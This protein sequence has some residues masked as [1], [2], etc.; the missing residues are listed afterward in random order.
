MDN[1]QKEELLNKCNS[2]T[3]AEDSSGV[4]YRIDSDWIIVNDSVYGYDL[5]I[6]IDESNML[7]SGVF[8]TED[9]K[10][11]YGY[12]FANVGTIHQS[13]D[14]NLYKFSAGFYNHVSMFYEAVVKIIQEVLNQ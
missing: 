7:S 11:I 14:E 13:K 3:F 12:K 6:G 4:S 5:Y 1:I 2:I 8:I 10:D 9:I